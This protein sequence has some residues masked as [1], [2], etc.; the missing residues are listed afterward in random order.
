M[1]NIIVR[2]RSGKTW[3]RNPMESKIVP[4]TSREDRRPE[5]RILK[6]H[7]C[8]ITSYLVKTCTKN[9]KINEVQVFEYIQCA[10]EKEESDQE[11]AISDCTP[12]EDNPFEKI[13]AFFEITEVH[14]H[15]PQ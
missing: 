1:E 10:E 2:T 3:T 4:K 13:T 7:Q 8:G 11:F 14:T 5:R 15:F 9:S 12:A 6:Y